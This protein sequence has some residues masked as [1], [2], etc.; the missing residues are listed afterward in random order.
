[1]IGTSLQL[2]ARRSLA[3]WRL[4]SA[5][6]AGVVL[7]VTIMATTVIYFEALRDLALQYAVSREAP[8]DLDVRLRGASLPVNRTEHEAILG[9]VETSIDRSLGPYLAGRQ[10]GIRSSAFEVQP[11]AADREAEAAGF[12]GSVKRRV[13]FVVFPGIE[14]HVEMV[15]GR[16]PGAVAR[17]AAGEVLRPEVMVPLEAARE[18]GWSVG[19]SLVAGP[20]WDEANPPAEPV[21]TGLFTR[22]DPDDPFWGIHDAVFGFA[23]ARFSFAIAVVPEPVFIDVLGP[24][25]PNM[26]STYGWWLDT[27]TSEMRASSVDSV[28]SG[29][30]TLK[31]DLRPIVDGYW[32]ATELDE[33][34]SSFEEKLFFNRLPMLIVLVIVVLVVLYYA[35][36]LASLLVD[37]QREEISLL[38]TRGASGTQVV[39]V[40]VIEAAIL[41]VLAVAVGPLLGALVTRFAGVVPWFSDLN[42]G[43]P[44][45]VHLGWD[46][47]RMA[48][49]GG[50]L[51]FGA[52]FLPAFR[53]ARVGLLA[54]RRGAARPA[55]RPAFQRYYLDL[56]LL[57]LA[58]L[59]FSQLQ[60]R[61]SVAAENLAGRTTVDQITLAVPALFMV[62]A[63]IVLLRLFPV[64]MDLLGRALSSRFM[65]RLVSPTL[66]LGL[67]QMARNPAHY[68]RLSLLFILTAGLGVFAANFGATLDRSFTERVLHRTGADVRIEGI[69]PRLGGTSDSPIKRAERVTGV[70]IAS[71]VMRSEGS[72]D[73]GFTTDSYEMLAVDP[74]TFVKVG[75][76]RSDYFDG[77]LE[78]QLSLIKTDVDLGIEL[79]AGTQSM[80]VRV[81]PEVSSPNALMVAMLRDANGRYFAAFLGDLTPQPADPRGGYFRGGEHCEV[82]AP[83]RYAGWPADYPGTGVTAGPAPAPLWCTLR[84]GLVT[85]TG[86]RPSLIPAPPVSLIGFAVVRRQGG[87]EPLRPGSVLIDEITAMTRGGESV[88]LAT[89][90]EPD[91]LERWHNLAQ[92][93]QA[94]ADT[95][96]PALDAADEPIPGVVVF[97]WGAIQPGEARGFYVGDAP[98]PV[99]VLA[100]RAFLELTSHKVGDTLEVSQQ[101][102]R[103]FLRIAGTVRHFPTLDPDSAPFVLADLN[104]V[105]V[106]L[107]I[108]AVASD[109]QFNEIWLKV[110]AAEGDKVVSRLEFAFDRE[111]FVDRG[112]QLAATTVDPLVRAGWKVL[113]GLAFMTVLLVSGVGFLVHSQVSF[114]ARKRELA[115]LRTIGLT[116]RQLL[117]LVALEQVLVLGAAMAIGVFMGARLGGTI[118]PYLSNSGEGV[119]VVPP[120]VTE[121]D[122][123]ILGL[124][125][126]VLAGVVVAVM[127]AIL[128]SVRRMAIESVLRVGER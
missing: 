126:A 110:D 60:A 50:A 96:R 14:D 112:E 52:L 79:P 124:T 17:A 78:S 23:E 13:I 63:G 18:Y 62:A 99:P 24:H 72:I 89:F 85:I 113:L 111:R 71:P 36:T 40:F 49:I 84:G 69:R 114:Q 86:Q 68:S 128:V 32:Q 26:G 56:V 9:L 101:N 121:I 39:L 77:S 108:G 12:G 97:R 95:L 105:S 53:A 92:S 58:L 34:L 54:Y 127:A 11:T 103:L 21:I 61:G 87:L 38:R 35:I 55:T 83:P 22:L 45:P 93:R 81:R 47:Y 44:L 109:V 1:M 48:L 76:T 122:W 51:S 27:D 116:M 2:I 16:P 82:A 6:A 120:I 107:N 46:A 119:K 115:V 67:W 100:S 5:V 10:Y 70:E 8:A 29:L 19:D 74:E 25:F 7:A 73:R 64:S 98:E 41:S 102:A 118:M 4:L 15:S 66:V 123:P 37:A 94:E 3:N 20:G 30:A 88:P 125:F 33:V 59:L 80:S 31:A 43:Q 104:A 28:R 42:G 91:A 75:W 57:G 65:Y 90:D 106:Y 117:A